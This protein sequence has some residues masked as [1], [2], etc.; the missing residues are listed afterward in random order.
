MESNGH[1]LTV[2]DNGHRPFARSDWPPWTRLVPLA[3]LL[4][5]L[6]L[7][8]VGTVR[9]ATVPTTANHNEAALAQTGAASP[10]QTLADRFAPI[11]MLKQQTEACDEVGEPYVPA[12]VDITLGDPTVTLRRDVGGKG[13]GDDPI[14]KRGPT[15]A[16]LARKDGSY[17]LDI[18]G[19]SRTP[20]CDYE[21]F[22][23]SRME[24]RPPSVYAHIAT[25]PGHSGLALQYWFYYAYNRFNNL[26]ESDWETI[27]LTFEGS[28]VAEALGQQPQSVAFAQ[29]AGGETA[30]WTSSKLQKDGDHPIVYPASGSHAT[31]YDDD[32]YLGWGE[33]GSG[34]GCDNSTP[35]SVRTPLKAILTPDQPTASGPFAWL[36]FEGL[37]GEKDNPPYAGPTGP[38]TKP[39]W[40]APFTWQDGLRK[41]SIALPDAHTIG[42][43]P[44]KFFCAATEN[45]S[46]LFTLAKPY[47][48]ISWPLLALI[49]IIP[50][51]LVFAM[52]HSLGA[53]LVMFGRHLWLFLALGAVLLVLA[54][55]G[56]SIE[57]VARSFV[58]GRAFFDIL[59]IIAPSQLIIQ[60]GGALMQFI[61]WTIVTPAVVFAVAEI[62]AGR[63]PGVMA[64][65][66]AALG[67]FWTI[68]RAA[69][70]SSVIFIL[71]IISIIGIP[72]A[73]TKVVRWLFIVQ[74]VVLRGATW[75]NAR[76]ISEQVVIGRWLRALCLSL[77]IALVLALLAPVIGIVFMVWVVPSAVAANL[78]SGVV[79]AFLFP[80]IGIT[81]TLWFERSEQIGP[82]RRISWS[83]L[84][85]RIRFYRPVAA[86]AMASS[87]PTGPP[88]AVGTAEA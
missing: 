84:P 60:S 34:F 64:S 66:R 58:V 18:L 36:T 33:H 35:R 61:G 3:L 13:P 47:P 87:I 23:K 24:G 77:A 39:Q 85:W 56:N 25:E 54:T 63:K 81:M 8:R 5:I 78:V 28:T 48:W 6:I 71:L 67:H 10:E 12:P 44:T 41:S 65:Y 21:K 76:L 40:I 26:H 4:V 17:Y 53:A 27:Q 7:P 46:G 79:Y 73:I 82:A 52:R 70:L 72:W 2:S 51:L 15:A 83:M 80:L 75:R 74:A 43:N 20:G 32:I 16:D 69:A 19:K 37:W 11:A 50:V 14:V 59:D 38:N 30:A 55:V 42:P 62:R 9:A 68:I 86:P 31:Y 49:V 22:S 88:G 29:H 1:R 57:D 45:L